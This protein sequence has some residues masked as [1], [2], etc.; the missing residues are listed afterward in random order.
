MVTFRRFMFVF[1]CFTHFVLCA[2]LFCSR[3]KYVQSAHA[4]FFQ[5]DLKAQMMRGMQF[6]LIRAARE[7]YGVLDSLTTW[8]RTF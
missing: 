8:D 1:P 6:P 4:L 3:N 7:K 2:A 5:M